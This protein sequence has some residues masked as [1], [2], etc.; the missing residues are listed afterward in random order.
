MALSTNYQWAEPDNSS[1]VKNGASDIRTLGNAID[2]SVWSVG[3][4]QAGKNKII[5]GDFA[6]WQRGTSFTPVSLTGIY[7]ADR[8][9]LYRNGSG[10]TVTVS[11]QAFTA[12]TAPVAGY[13]GSFFYRFAQS[14]AGTG[15]TYSQYASERIEDVR[16]FAGQTATFS[17]WAKADANKNV[18]IEIYQGFGSGGSSDVTVAA[19]S[20]A[21]TTS[22]ARYSLTVSVPSITGKTIG[23]S[24]FLSVSLIDATLNT[25]KT[26]DTWGWQL[27]AG[28]TATPFQLAGGGTPQAELALCQRY[29]WRATTSV[30][31]S[32]FP[33]AGLARNTTIAEMTVSH[34]V[35]MR[36]A[37]VS[38][39]YSNVNVSDGVTLASGGTYF[40]LES[41]EI[42]AHVAITYGSGLTQYRTYFLQGA[43]GT[44]YLGFSA[45]L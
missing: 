23:T 42:A 38:V 19:T 44:C 10:A 33:G 18:T 8:Y 43:T 16:T 35:P 4:G 7:T 29:Y 1:L 25:T 21:L 26:I 39:D 27:E 22:W 31:Y 13:E 34:P 36:K 11:R 12:G 37:V 24:S 20:Q 6:I 9:N 41:T 3:F 15:A 32:Y 30:N 2:E 40:V 17:F 28:S 14:V 5:N 45:E